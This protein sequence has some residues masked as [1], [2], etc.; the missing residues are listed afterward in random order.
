MTWNDGTEG[1]RGLRGTPAGKLADIERARIRWASNRSQS[2]PRAWMSFSVCDSMSPS[3]SLHLSIPLMRSVD[4]RSERADERAREQER[5]SGVSQWGWSGVNLPNDAAS[6]I[7]LGCTARVT[8]SDI[9]VVSALQ[10]VIRGKGERS[11]DYF[12]PITSPLPSSPSFHSFSSLSAFLIAPIPSS[13][14]SSSPLHFSI[15]LKLV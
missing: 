14:S 5:E 8:S 1:G 15:S 11:I 9:I 7:T 12:H 10:R 6:H 13:L 3:P 4:R 2:P